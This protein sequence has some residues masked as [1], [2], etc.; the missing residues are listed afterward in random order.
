M[1]KERM[2]QLATVLENSPTNVVHVPNDGYLTFDME[3]YLESDQNCG[4]IGCIAGLAV[5]MF[6]PGELGRGLVGERVGKLAAEVLDLGWCDARRL[7]V[8]EDISAFVEWTAITPQQAGH[9]VRNFI[10]SED[11]DWWGVLGIETD[12]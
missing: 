5:M 6:R 3:N 12:E 4:T 11:P 1:N 10:A 7:F 8:P 9:A 2:E